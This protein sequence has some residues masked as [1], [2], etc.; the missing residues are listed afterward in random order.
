MKGTVS[1]RALKSRLASRYPGEPITEVLKN[2]PDEVSPEELIGKV[3]TWQAVIDAG[4]SHE[5]RR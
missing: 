3:A 4:K 1:I 5:K 2:E